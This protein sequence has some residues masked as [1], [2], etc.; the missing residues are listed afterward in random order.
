MVKIYRILYALSLFIP[1]DCVE[2]LTNINNPIF[3]AHT[4]CITQGFV[5]M[6]VGYILLMTT[7][8]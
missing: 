7:A 5:C 8:N 3:A 1:A 4:L 6:G 2:T